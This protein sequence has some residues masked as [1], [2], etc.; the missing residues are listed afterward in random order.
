MKCPKCGSMVSPERV[1]GKKCKGMPGVM[2]VICSS[3]GYTR[4]ADKPKR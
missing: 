2:Y 3:C 1:D 4:K